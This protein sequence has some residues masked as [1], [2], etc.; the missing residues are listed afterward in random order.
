MRN[1]SEVYQRFSVNKVSSL[2]STMLSRHIIHNYQFNWARCL[3]GNY[4][5]L[6]TSVYEAIFLKPNFWASASTTLT[7]MIKPA[8]SI[9]VRNGSDIS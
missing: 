8:G 3:A 5:V 9:V 4:I 2:L 1:T 6:Y 7:F